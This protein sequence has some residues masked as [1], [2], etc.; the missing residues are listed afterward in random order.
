M[1]ETPEMD[2]EVV[3]EPDNSREAV[4]EDHLNPPMTTAPLDPNAGLDQGYL[5]DADARN[6]ELGESE[7]IPHAPA[8]DPAAEL[9]DTSDP[10]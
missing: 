7:A 10:S 9:P 5:E 3:P 8:A 1:S 4:E 2:E 6:D